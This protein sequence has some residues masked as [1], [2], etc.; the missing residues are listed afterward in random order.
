M[1][2]VLKNEENAL[3]KSCLTGNRRQCATE[4]V[5][6]NALLHYPSWVFKDE[7]ALL[8]TLV[9]IGPGDCKKIV[10]PVKW[11]SMHT[12]KHISSYHRNHGNLP[13]PRKPFFIN[14]FILLQTVERFQLMLRTSAMMSILFPHWESYPHSTEYCRNMLEI[15][16]IFHCKRNIIATFLSHIAKYFIATLQF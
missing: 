5:W 10:W 9:L 3:Y 2:I 7:P 14:N 12:I 6:G 11:K 1:T 8:G 15:F 16:P 4:Y 13:G